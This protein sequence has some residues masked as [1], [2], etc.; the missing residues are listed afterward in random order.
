MAFAIWL[1][2][3]GGIIFC[4]ERSSSSGSAASLDEDSSQRFPPGLIQSIAFIGKQ[5]NKSLWNWGY[6]EDGAD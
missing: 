1:E 5:F 6:F 4:A 3:S 2:N